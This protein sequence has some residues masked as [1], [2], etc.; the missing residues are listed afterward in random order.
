MPS[1]KASFMEAAAGNS[2]LSTP[3]PPPRR[4]RLGAWLQGEINAKDATY[5]LI[6]ACFLTGFTS[7]VTFTACYIWCGFFSGAGGCSVR[8]IDRRTGA[9]SYL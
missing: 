8:E 7:S 1:D 6:W 4:L 9:D 2:G 5:Q 3:T